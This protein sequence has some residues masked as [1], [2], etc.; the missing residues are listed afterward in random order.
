MYILIEMLQKRAASVVHT[1][2]YLLIELFLEL[3]ECLSDRLWCAAILVDR[4]NTLLEV[5]SGL[6]AA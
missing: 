3:I 5:E 2:A 6:N 4:K 1:A